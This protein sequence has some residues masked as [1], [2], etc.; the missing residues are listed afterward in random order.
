MQSSKYSKASLK[1]KKP[2]ENLNFSSRL[3]GA[4]TVQEIVWQ[5]SEILYG[6]KYNVHFGCF[7][8]YSLVISAHKYKT[9]LRKLSRTFF[10]KNWFYE[11]WDNYN[12]YDPMVLKFPYFCVVVMT[13]A[14]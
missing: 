9:F 7:K 8:K 12:I 4:S 1:L 14:A 3:C 2:S 5:S 11:A 6:V 13:V 10:K